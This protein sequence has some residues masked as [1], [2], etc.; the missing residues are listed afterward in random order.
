M[1]DEN[2]LVQEVPV[3]LSKQVSSVAVHP[4]RAAEAM[5]PKDVDGRDLVSTVTLDNETAAAPIAAGDRLERDHRQLRHTE[6][7]TVPC[8]PW[9]TCPSAAFLLARHAVGQF[10]SRPL[11]PHRRHRAAGAGRR[12]GAVVQAL[13]PQPPLRKGS[14]KNYRQHA[15]R[16]RRH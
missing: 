16:G 1:L 9:P 4:R 12:S 2:E 11:H 6:Y 7:V 10:F 3:A 13:W 14:S 8:W 5:L 15:Y